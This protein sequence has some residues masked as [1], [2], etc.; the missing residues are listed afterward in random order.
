MRVLIVDDVAALRKLVRYVLSGAPRFHV[1]GEAADG[2][3]AIDMAREI[4]PD[5]VLLDVS[6]PK[7]D[8]LEALPRIRYACPNARILVLSGFQES[9][10][11]DMARSLGADGFIEKGAPPDELLARLIV[12]VEGRR[13]PAQDTH[14]TRA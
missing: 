9:R 11:G 4:Q 3:A 7:M 10:L 14:H 1:A 8:G 12:A 5:L 6:M 13:E 2:Q